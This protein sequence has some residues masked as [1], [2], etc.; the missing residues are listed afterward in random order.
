[1]M[2]N[3]TNPRLW[4]ILPTLNEAPT[5]VHLVPGLLALAP[6]LGI[7][8]IDDHSTDGSATIWETWHKRV[9]DRVSI[10]HRSGALGLGTAYRTVF[11]DP[12]IQAAS[13][14]LQMDGDGSHQLRDVRCLLAQRGSTPLIDLWIGSR[15]VAGGSTPGWPL[16]RRWL[17]RAGSWYTRQIVNSPVRDLTT[18]LKLWRGDLV[19]QM[20]WDT[21]EETGYGFQIA[22][23]LHAQWLGARIAEW[24]ITFVPR[25]AGHS[26][27]SG[28]ILWE[29]AQTPWRLR[30]LRQH[31]PWLS[32]PGI[33][34]IS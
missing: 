10:I 11:Q 24:P 28:A 27:L 2:A 21:C 13:W 31:Q 23:T 19:R 1:M 14:V 29:A 22:T 20:P 4:C 8:G 25:Q 6:D 5:L 16:R 33:H 15:Y 7:F 18:G 30:R 32:T 26:K 34:R 9:P 12:V 17:S 3:L